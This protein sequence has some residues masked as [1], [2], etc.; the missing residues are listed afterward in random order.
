MKSVF[1]FLAILFF[2]IF[3]LGVQASSDD[4]FET[5]GIQMV[6][7]DEVEG[8]KAFI[9]HQCA[10]CHS[11]FY[12]RALPKPTSDV[13]GPVLGRPDRLH[14]PADI[15][16]AIIS[17]SHEI[18]KDYKGEL[19]LD[20]TSPMVRLTH[21]MTVQELLDIATYLMDVQDL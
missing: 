5:G 11:V 2:F 9:K 16:N 10:S 18:S 8:R 21:V 1:S 3:P 14:L 6:R 13:D 17:P 4:Y 15:M 20:G 19:T 7:A 12:D